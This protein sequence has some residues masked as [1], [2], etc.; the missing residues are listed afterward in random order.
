MKWE[1]PKLIVLVRGRPE[2]AVLQ[3]CRN[4]GV[5]PVSGSSTQKTGCRLRTAG[6]CPSTDCRTILGS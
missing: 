2:E 6:N 5:V 4:T 1:T 3:N